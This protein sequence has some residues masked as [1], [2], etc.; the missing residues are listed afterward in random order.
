MEAK[1]KRPSA[2]ISYRLRK[3]LRDE[4]GVGMFGGH[5]RGIRAHEWPR[6]AVCGAPMCHMAQLESGAWLDLGAFSRMTL[7]ICHATGGRC[8]DWDP[9]K[10]ANAVVLSRGRDDNLYD[11]PP[12]VRV[13]RR[14]QLGIDAPFDER[15]VMADVKAKGLPMRDALE[16][17]RHDKIGGGAVWLHGDA[18]PAGVNG[19]PMRL[20]LQMTTDLVRFDITPTGMAYV[21]F[22]P[23]ERGEKAAR[24]LW[25]GS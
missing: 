14:M 23:S 2:W 7:F 5:P 9:Y 6:C 18:T 15:T 1:L 8:E 13:Y 25:Q 10:G 16:K 4:E 19:D 22:D 20:V 21:F 3:A 12:T 11:G 17:L 24:L